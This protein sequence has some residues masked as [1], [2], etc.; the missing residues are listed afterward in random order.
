MGIPERL[1]HIWIGPK[2]VPEKWLRT[3]R[4]KHP[5]AA[6]TLYDNDFLDRFPF[7]CRA[8]IDAMLERRSYPGVADLM[9][10]E[11][12]AEFGGLLPG[13]D[14]IC[15]RST[16]GL[17][18]RECAYTVYENELLRGRLVSP[19]LAC[20]PGNPFVVALVERLAE[21]DPDQLGMPW[22][23]TGNLFCTR[24]IEELNP[25]IEVFPSYFFNPLHYTGVLDPDA[26][27]AYALQVWGSTVD[28]YKDASQRGL[29]GWWARRAE[30]RARRRGAQ[31]LNE[32]ERR[33]MRQKMA[34]M[35]RLFPDALEGGA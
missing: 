15:L 27:Q 7:K 25:D 30:R 12:L 3:W 10:Y 33:N 24:M 6:Y 1:G 26:K 20:E 34:E 8:Q 32:I 16:D 13:A 18:E 2:P 22:V 11:I 21:T 28:A 23:A 31:V 29:S 19:I 17:F 14:S 5:R 9:R 4:E 35:E